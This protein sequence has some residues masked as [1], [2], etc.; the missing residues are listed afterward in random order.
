M[1]KIVGFVQ[2]Q[3]FRVSFKELEYLP[4]FSMSDNQLGYTSLTISS[5]KTHAHHLIVKY[6]N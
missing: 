5:K 4:S 2:L 1:H 3:S 6:Y